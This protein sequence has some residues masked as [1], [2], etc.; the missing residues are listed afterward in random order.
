MIG[1]AALVD[2][3]ERDSWR[4]KTDGPWLYAAKRIAGRAMP[5]AFSPDGG[6]V[7]TL[8][9]DPCGALQRLGAWGEI[10]RQV[11]LFGR[12]DAAA[13]IADALTP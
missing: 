1:R 6:R 11:S 13:A 12:H 2:Q 7:V 4:V 8:R 5:G 9:I 10:E 3:L